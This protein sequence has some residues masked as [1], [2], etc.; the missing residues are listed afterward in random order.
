[1]SDRTREQLLEEFFRLQNVHQVAN[2]VVML[3]E[4]EKELIKDVTKMYMD[5]MTKAYNEK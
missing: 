5:T 4:S 2:W 1:M 3:T